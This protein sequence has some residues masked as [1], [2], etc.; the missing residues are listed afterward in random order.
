LARL[1]PCYRRVVL[2]DFTPT[3]AAS[4]NDLVELVKRNL[5]TSDWC[6]ENHVEVGCLT[7]R[8]MSPDACLV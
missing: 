7:I 2:L 1:P 6:D 3:H 4:Y 8:S 5:L